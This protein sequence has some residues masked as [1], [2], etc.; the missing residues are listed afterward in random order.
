MSPFK[1]TLRPFADDFLEILERARAAG[2]GTQLLTGDC[3]SGS[4]EV[5]ALAKEHGEYNFG[6]VPA[7]MS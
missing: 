6:P 2:V 5:I 4:K 7:L 3:L 1:L